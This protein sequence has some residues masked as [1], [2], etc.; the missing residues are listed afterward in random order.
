MLDENRIVIA[1]EKIARW[2]SAIGISFGI[3][4]GFIIGILILLLC[5]CYGSQS[6]YEI[7]IDENREWH[8]VPE[9]KSDYPPDNFLTEDYWVAPESG[10][11]EW[12]SNGSAPVLI[13][14]EYTLVDTTDAVNTT[15]E[16]SFEWKYSFNLTTFDNIIAN[17]ET[18]IDSIRHNPNLNYYHNGHW[19]GHIADNIEWVVKTNHY[20]KLKINGEDYRIKLIKE[21]E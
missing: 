12:S 20:L 19:V 3:V 1:L 6:D 5:G 2:V 14:K 9:T 17:V 4:S 10:T 8:E 21:E 18:V 15:D 13:E 11:Y 16:V 7:M